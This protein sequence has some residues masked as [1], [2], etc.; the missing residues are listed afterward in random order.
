MVTSV[1]TPLAGRGLINLDRFFAMILGANIGTTFTGIVAAFAAPEDRFKPALQ[2]ALCHFLINVTGTLWIYPIPIV[3]KIP[4]KIATYLGD[5]CER[6]RWFIFAYMGILFYFVPALF[7]G[8]S[9]INHWAAYIVAGIMFYLIA[10]IIL[11]NFLQSKM[12][13]FL[14]K[15]LRNWE[16]LPNYMTSLEPVDKVVNDL[17]SSIRKNSSKFAEIL[18][19]RHKNGPKAT[20]N[21]GN[22]C[23]GTVGGDSQMEMCS[24]MENCPTHTEFYGIRDEFSEFSGGIFV[25]PANAKSTNSPPSAPN[26]S[27]SNMI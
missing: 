9:L 17:K 20:N 10:G 12:P 3:R 22:I 8:L 25:I 16:F 5:V 4:L 21:L 27:M 1:L 6:Y 13:T 18:F 15:V 26:S 24:H 11:I 19:N 23:I 14:P 2:I 7:L